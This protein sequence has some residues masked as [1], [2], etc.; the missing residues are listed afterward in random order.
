MK[1]IVEMPF[2]WQ[3]DNNGFPADNLDRAKYARFLT[4]FLV[5]KGSEK[6]YVLNVNASWG[7][8]KTWFLRRWSEEVKKNYPVVFVDA[9]K[10]DHSKDP[11]LSVVSAISKD[12]EPLIDVRFK[13]SAITRKSWL[14]LKSIAPEL[15]KGIVKKY[16]SLDVDEVSKAINNNDASSI[17]GVGAKAVEKLIKFHD[18]TNSS[19]EDFKEATSKYLDLIVSK[20]DKELPLFVFIDELDRCRPTYAIEMLE[21]IKHIFDMDNV[22]FI[23]ATDKDQLQHSIKAVYGSGFNSTKYLD[24]FFD[25]SITLRNT[26]LFDYISNMVSNSNVLTDYFSRS[27]CSWMMPVNNLEKTSERVEWLSTIA[28]CFYMDLRTTK[29]W[30][31]R[32]EASILSSG[33]R[34]DFVFLSYLLALN[35]VSGITYA[36]VANTTSIMSGDF[37]NKYMSDLY[38]DMVDPNIKLNFSFDCSVLGNKLDIKNSNSYMENPLKEVSF[39]LGIHELFFSCHTC[40]NV[41]DPRKFIEE[42]RFSLVQRLMKG[43]QDSNIIDIELMQVVILINNKNISFND[44]IDIVELAMILE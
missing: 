21:T 13:D 42:Q 37:K 38:R 27:D 22:V 2:E 20:S 3:S 32:L 43:A 34:I 39:T 26:S 11:F 16:L 15:T 29:Q 6:N 35:C 17:A 10:S 24:R 7:A 33:D 44:Y 23:I 41:I 1:N 36:N 25:R 5:A 12:L 9:W 30:M 31:E 19:I 28:Q 40:L 18:E 8:G 14:L 4:D